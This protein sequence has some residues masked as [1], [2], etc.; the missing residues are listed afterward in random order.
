M[1]KLLG[2]LLILCLLA[3]ACTADGKAEQTGGILLSDSA[4]IQLDKH[5]Q[6]IA[7]EDL[8]NR[9]KLS[10]FEEAGIYVRLK[11]VEKTGNDTASV[12]IL[13]EKEENMLEIKADALLQYRYFE[14]SENI[15]DLE[16]YWG[17]LTLSEDEII[18]TSLND[19]QIWS[20][21]SF[22]KMEKVFD[23]S[24]LPGG[25]R[26]LADTVKNRGGYTTA[27]YAPGEQGVAVMNEDGSF[28]RKHIFIQ[29]RPYVYFGAKT[30]EA[31]GVRY[32][33]DFCLTQRNY[34]CYIDPR[35]TMLAFFN[36]D[37]EIRD[38]FVYDMEKEIIICVDLLFSHRENDKGFYVFT[39]K[40]I[41]AYP[42]FEEENMCM[43]L[44][45]ENHTATESFYF[46]G[47]KILSAFGCDWSTGRRD[48]VFFDTS[49]GKETLSAYFPRTKQTLKI[50]FEHGT[51]SADNPD[52][53]V[54]FKPL[55]KTED[56]KFSLL[57]EEV[58][59]GEK[60]IYLQENFT[61]RTKQLREETGAVKCGFYENGDPWVLTD[62]ALQVFSA[63]ISDSIMK[64]VFYG[65]KEWSQTVKERVILSALYDDDSKSY[66]VLY[67]DIPYTSPGESLYVSGN[68]LR[69]K[70]TYKIITVNSDGMVIMHCDTG[71]NALRASGGLYP[72]SLCREAENKLSLY[73]Y[74]GSIGTPTDEYYENVIA[75]GWL[76]T[77]TKEYTETQSFEY[78][79]M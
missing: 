68:S 9:G 1:K 78:N 56:G 26:Y 39:C 34:I 42:Q 59:T 62:H 19:I 55:A 49:N 60:G 40:G 6:D 30:A 23:F 45:M 79:I 7:V 11:S 58:P 64:F 57:L 65:G 27:Y 69:I 12:T 10:L 4:N 20:A 22:E 35:Q 72:C 48:T 53:T 70:S 46:D 76:D 2:I 52:I 50:D 38:G 28:F 32:N 36:K 33:M 41:S 29:K 66:S 31:E 75:S 3:T 67:I 8:L 25:R 16:V 44:K 61:G 18:F 17:N 24:F 71:V 13:L 15:I 74:G 47:G 5:I 14:E 77:D 37:S 73:V 51:V 21:D 54:D 43:A 63:D